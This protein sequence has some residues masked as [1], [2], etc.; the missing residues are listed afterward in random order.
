MSLTDRQGILILIA[1][2]A[3]KFLNTR[4]VSSARGRHFSF[5]SSFNT[6]FK[7]ALL[8]LPQTDR[9][10]HEIV[11]VE[12]LVPS[13]FFYSGNKLRTSTSASAL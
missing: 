12:V 1:A 13:K 7:I 8:L 3:Y 2:I 11:K 9:A 4:K 10:A 6:R 5:F